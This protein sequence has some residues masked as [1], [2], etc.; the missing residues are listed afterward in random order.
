MRFCFNVVGKNNALLDQNKTKRCGD[1][2]EKN[3]HQYRS[4]IF[5]LVEKGK[6][7]RGSKKKKSEEVFGD[8]GA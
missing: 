2:A 8:A 3:P 5:R 4:D 6:I 7:K 1:P